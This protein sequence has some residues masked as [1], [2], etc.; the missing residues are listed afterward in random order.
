MTNHARLDLRGITIVRTDAE[1]EC[2]DIDDWF[3]AK[4]ANLVL[5]PGHISESELCNAVADA[6]LILMCYTTISANVIQ[7]ASHL[8]G[9]VK[10]GV[11]IDAI[12]ITA[13]TKHGIPVVNVP[14]YAEQTVAEGA[15]CLM[16]ALVK[17]LL[18]IH[19]AM[20]QNGWIDPTAHWM[21]ND[22][23]S[24]CVAIVGAGR[25]GRAFARMAGQG[26]GA[27]VIAYDPHADSQELH[28]LGIKKVDDL[29]LL[30]EQADIVSMHTVLNNATHTMIGAEEFAAMRRQP[31][32]INVS[33]GALID[34]SA[35]LNALNTKQISAAGLDVFT[36]EPLNR[37]SHPLASLYERENVILSPHMTFFT[38]E[39]MQRLTDDTLARCAEVLLGNSVTVRSND[40]RLLAQHGVLNVT[41]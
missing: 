1:I 8:R 9:I 41:R 37:S 21:G 23:H 14:E 31:V 24:K 19:H 22:I 29:H 35:L 6:H 16:L 2:T 12:D 15:F 7:A 36:D 34:E 33:R 28:A 20:Q 3:I 17:K 4:G 39:A 10:Y 13:A 40:P 26:F 11:G 30:L 32:L 18:P 38:K 5:L 27:R 25:I